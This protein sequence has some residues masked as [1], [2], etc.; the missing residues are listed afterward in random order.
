MFLLVFSPFFVPTKIN[1]VR[2]GITLLITSA[3]TLTIRTQQCA[4]RSSC[5]FLLMSMALTLTKH[6][7]LRETLFLILTTPLC[8]RLLRSGLLIPSVSYFLVCTC[9]LMRLIVAIRSSCLLTLTATPI[10]S[11]QLQYCG[12]TLFV[13]LTFLFCLVT[14]LMVSLT[15][16]QTF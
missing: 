12:T 15:C 2:I 5:V 14:R 7:I 6:L 11:P 10:F 4:D 8:L 16:I 9:L 13:W 3:S 1:M